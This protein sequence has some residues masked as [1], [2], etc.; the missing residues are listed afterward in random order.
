[1]IYNINHH[2]IGKF[3][4][5]CLAHPIHWRVDELHAKCLAHNDSMI[6]IDGTLISIMR[7]QSPDDSNGTNQIQLVKI[8]PVQRNILQVTI[9]VV[10]TLNATWVAHGQVRNMMNQ[11]FVTRVDHLSQKE[12]TEA[13]QVV[14][15]LILEHFPVLAR[16]YPYYLVISWPIS[17]DNR[18]HDWHCC[19][20]LLL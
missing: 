11:P 9:W 4:V 6:K 14:I 15:D 16:S 3:L 13:P 1:M 2:R 20:P 18:H 17:V 7:S 5:H 10:W 8:F 12:N 19:F